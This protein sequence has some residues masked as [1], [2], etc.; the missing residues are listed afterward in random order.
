VKNTTDEV[1]DRSEVLTGAVLGARLLG[2]LSNTS[3]RRIFVPVLA[4]IG[5]EM[6]LHGLRVGP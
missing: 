3:V 4:L 2:R 5:I 1:H 6:I